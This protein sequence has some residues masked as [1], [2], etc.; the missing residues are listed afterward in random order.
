MK[1]CFMGLGH[2]NG[3]KSLPKTL[4]L[5]GSIEQIADRIKNSNIGIYKFLQQRTHLDYFGVAHY[6]KDLLLIMLSVVHRITLSSSLVDFF[7]VIF[8]LLKDLMNKPYSYVLEKFANK[9]YSLFNYVLAEYHNLTVSAAGIPIAQGSE[10]DFLS[11]LKSLLRNKESLYESEFYARFSSFA[12]L[13]VCLPVCEALGIDCTTFGFSE[14]VQ[15]RLKSSYNKKHIVSIYEKI[16]EDTL[17]F[18]DRFVVFK[19]HGSFNSIFIDDDEL[20]IFSD[21]FETMNYYFDKLEIIENSG[22]TLLEYYRKCDDMVTQCD[23]FLEFFKRDAHAIKQLKY[24]RSTLV[25][26]RMRSSDKLNVTAERK[27]PFAFVL[28]GPPSIGKSGII[29]KIL[30]LL[31]DHC[32]GLG[33]S[34]DVYSKD[35]KYHYNHS[36]RYMSEFKRSHRVCIIDDA[37]QFNAEIT[38]SDGGGAIKHTIDFINPVP[39]VTAQAD[40][41]NKGMI[42]FMCDYVALTT[43]I[44]DAGM[45]VVFDKKSGAKRRFLFIDVEVKPE[46][47]KKGTTMLDGCDNP[48]NHDMHLYIPR[49]YQCVGESYNTK[50]WDSTTRSFN[51]SDPLKMDLKGL[52]DVLLCM[53]SKH[54]F[55]ESIAKQSVDIFMDSPYCNVHKTKMCLCGCQAISEGDGRLIW[56]KSQSKQYIKEFFEERRRKEEEERVFYARFTWYDKLICLWFSLYYTCYTYF[57][58]I[59]ALQ[60]YR[61]NM[62][63]RILL[64]YGMLA[65]VSLITVV[66]SFFWLKSLFVSPFSEGGNISSE[67]KEPRSKNPWVTKVQEV[68]RMTG[69]SA[70]MTMEQLRSA[71]KNNC[72]HIIFYLSTG[73]KVKCKGFALCGNSILIPGHMYAWM[74]EDGIDS[75]D[76]IRHDLSTKIGP[77][78]FKRSVCSDNFLDIPDND[79]TIMFSSSFGSFRDVRDYILSDPVYGKCTGYFLSRGESGLLTEN[80][81]NCME[82]ELVKYYDQNTNKNFIG[83]GYRVHMDYATSL[84]DCC[85]PY[86]IQTMN[87]CGI[88]GL[89]CAS[90]S[91]LIDKFPQFEGICFARII[92]SSVIKQIKQPSFNG[93]DL[94]YHYNT[95]QDLTVHE[96]IHYKSVLNDLSGTCN[97]YGSLKIHRPKLKSSV[98]HTL[99]CQDVLDHYNMFEPDYFSPATISFKKAL[100]QN[101]EPCLDKPN[102]NQKYLSMS[103]KS[104]YKWYSRVIEE[105]GIYVPN[106]PYTRLVGVNGLDSVDYIDRLPISTSGGFAHKGRKEKYLIQL[107]SQRDHVVCYDLCP[108]VALEYDRLVD[109]Y[110][111]GKRGNVVWDFNFKDEP[112][113][114]SKLQQNK[115]RIFN[116]GPLHFNVLFRQY[117]M[118]C[119]PLFTGEHR[120]KFGIA[121]GANATG[122]DWKILY[123]HVI[124]H[125]KNRIIA[126][127]Y[128]SFDKMMTPQEIESVFN[129]LLSIMAA[130]GWSEEDLLIARGLSVDVIY[131]L[132]NC[133]GTLVEFFGSNPSGGPLTTPIN[134]IN[135]IQ[136]LMMATMY[137]EDVYGIRQVDYDNFMDSALSLLTYGDDNIMSSRF[138][139]LTHTS[140]SRAFSEMGIQYTMADKRSESIPFIDIQEAD[141]LKRRFI[142]GTH[143]SNT[144]AAPLDRKSIIKSLTVCV[145]SRAIAFETQNAAIIDSAN[146]EFFQYGKVVFEAE[147]EFLL[148]L[149]RKHGL[150]AHLPTGKLATY[151]EIYEQNYL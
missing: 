148:F 26:C 113:S 140:I 39:Y 44:E 18:I 32:R 47:R 94:N 138:N 37:G 61:T 125:G 87:G 30:S 57:N 100:I 20:R 143:G 17:Y 15:K 12:S 111:Q 149:L 124:K 10:R 43:N 122:K 119:L 73:H 117:F 28:H 118:W 35:M 1:N 8:Q 96:D 27:T 95:T 108:E 103:E 52:S 88:A 62:R 84:G 40:L 56:A 150:E 24:Q 76:I 23:K 78:V 85:A 67:Q 151:E 46:Y 89:H 114:L 11:K 91:S 38:K 93:I 4:N 5:E 41:H 145:K 36:D 59:K 7:W 14:I 22:M 50:Y 129:I 55:Q 141:F 19:E 25:R 60:T 81:V 82:Y 139:W 75:V 112:I 33:V 137:L 131:P 29:D 105:N 135:N 109:S 49:V 102:I 147:R 6:N 127:D 16:L 3:L 2:P 133:F 86:L 130:H 58:P 48:N 132:S 97:V 123:E 64:Q 45:S 31:F 136:K 42:P 104:V 53:L 72:C 107:P 144:V 21:D 90:F 68:T 54:H 121:I 63:N 116:S 34:N 66:Q 77:S 98:T 13:I 99:M 126:G 92:D 51:S 79:F 83:P 115:C 101:L 70:N 142:V 71:V 128:K 69:K 146:R 134:S 74:K 80:K 110:K 106:G 9:V 120:H 65:F